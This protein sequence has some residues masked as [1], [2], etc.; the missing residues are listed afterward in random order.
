MSEDVAAVF[1]DAARLDKAVGG[2]PIEY[3]MMW[4]FAG[5]VCH[6]ITSDEVAK[7][8]KLAYNPIL[9][10]ERLGLIEAWGDEEAGQ[11]VMTDRGR[12]LYEY[13]QRGKVG[14]WAARLTTRA[15]ASISILMTVVG[16][17]VIWGDKI[18]NLVLKVIQFLREF[19]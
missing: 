4:L 9:E 18:V 7:H 10:L 2:I 15:K 13:Q 3:G 5:W 1:A 17:L 12:K 19:N 11:M 16:A 6:L 8:E 14:Q